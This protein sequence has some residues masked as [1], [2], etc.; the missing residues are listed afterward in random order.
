M[1]K[2]V[3]VLVEVH[4]SPCFYKMNLKIDIDGPV[5]GVVRVFPD[6]ERD[7]CAEH[8]H[9]FRKEIARFILGGDHGDE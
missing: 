9:E 5:F 3:I 4:D 7:L 1:I 2:E 6:G 8:S